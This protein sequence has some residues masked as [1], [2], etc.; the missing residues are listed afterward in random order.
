MQIQ[1]ES[2]HGKRALKLL[3]PSK[4]TI[5]ES[6]LEFGIKRLSSTSLLIHSNVS[7]LFAQSVMIYAVNV[8]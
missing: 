7:D 1:A 4:H 2:C 8:K 3:R 5:S 6:K